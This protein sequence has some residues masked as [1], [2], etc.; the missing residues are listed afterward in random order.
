MRMSKLL[1]AAVVVA[2]LIVACGGE[3]TDT[4]DTTIADGSEPTTTTT[5]GTESAPETTTTAPTDD[6]SAGA[7]T[8]TIGD[9]SW[10]FPV[11][12]ECTVG[13]ETDPDYREFIGETADGSAQLNVAW[14]GEGELSGL[15]GAGV[16]AVVD[17]NDWTYASSYAGADGL[18]EITVRDDGADGVAEVGVVGIDAPEGLS[19]MSWS[20][21]C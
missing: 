7:A 16:D 14:F 2:M 13:T 1:P 8:A 6:G 5:T 3:G 18:F 12:L 9:R 19:E 11:V 4:T 17:G 10:E 21:S 20:F 15:N